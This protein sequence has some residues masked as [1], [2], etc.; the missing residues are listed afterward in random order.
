MRNGLRV[1]DWNRRDGCFRSVLRAI[2]ARHVQVPDLAP[3]FPQFD[4]NSRKFV[5]LIRS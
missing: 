2:L 5:G 3:V 4:N 1:R